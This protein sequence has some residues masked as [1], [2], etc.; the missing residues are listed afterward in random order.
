MES[1]VQIRISGEG[2]LAKLRKSL[3]EAKLLTR[4]NFYNSPAGYQAKAC[5]RPLLYGGELPG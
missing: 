1:H 4:M 3:S 2:K 5:L